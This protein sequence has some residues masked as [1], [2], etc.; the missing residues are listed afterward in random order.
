MRPIEAFRGWNAA[1]ARGVA[2]AVACCCLALTT[3]LQPNGA[4]GA[5]PCDTVASEGDI[6]ACIDQLHRQMMARLA[7]RS[8]ADAELMMLVAKDICP[9][10]ARAASPCD[11]VASVQGDIAACIDQL[12]RQ[13]MAKLA[14]RLSARPDRDAVADFCDYV[15]GKKQ[16]DADAQMRPARRRSIRPEPATSP[17]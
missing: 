7:A 17:D 3:L 11:N 4:R 16:S 2:G 8:D 9:A 5:S 14:A 10:A 12:H 15:A 6:A 1:S 13:M